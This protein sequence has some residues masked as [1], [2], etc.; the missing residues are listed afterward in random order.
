M[1]FCRFCFCSVLSKYFVKPIQRIPLS[2]ERSHHWN[3][4]NHKS[5]CFHSEHMRLFSAFRSN[6]RESKYNTL[7]HAEGKHTSIRDFWNVSFMCFSFN[8]C[9]INCK[10]KAQPVYLGLLQKYQ[11]EKQK[12]VLVKWKFKSKS[13]ADIKPV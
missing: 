3:L 10:W 7:I 1:H 11:S 8:M 9:L 4:A 6:E 2:F 13:S 12:N 5:K